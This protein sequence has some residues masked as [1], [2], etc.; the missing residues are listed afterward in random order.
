MDNSKEGG[1]VNKPHVLYGTDYDYWKAKM[2]DF[3]NP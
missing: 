1:S 2:I 3:L